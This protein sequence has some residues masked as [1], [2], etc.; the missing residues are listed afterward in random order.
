MQSSWPKNAIWDLNR[1]KWRER[2]IL[3]SLSLFNNPF[4]L[5][6]PTKGTTCLNQ[7]FN[8]WLDDLQNIC[9]K[10]GLKTL[11]SP[12]EDIR[13]RLNDMQLSWTKNAISNLNCMKW[14]K[15]CIYVSHFL[16]NNCLNAGHLGYYCSPWAHNFEIKCFMS[17]WSIYRLCSKYWLQ[18]WLYPYDDIRI[19][20][21]DM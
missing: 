8:V 6:V 12:N 9:A 7:V 10:L 2:C 11:L 4:G 15:W 14:S 16:F 18:T 17:D 20:L 5:P 3:F 1:K 13:I 21:L 19:C